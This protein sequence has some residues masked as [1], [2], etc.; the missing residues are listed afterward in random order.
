MTSPGRHF[1]GQLRAGGQELDNPWAE[2]VFAQI[3]DEVVLSVNQ[4]EVARLPTP[5]ITRTEQ[6]DVVLIEGADQAL[7]FR[8][9]DPTAFAEAVLPPL[10]TAELIAAASETPEDATLI[11]EPI[12]E[13]LDEAPIDAEPV[14]EVAA[15]WWRSWLVIIG[16]LLLLLILFLAFC[17][18][19]PETGISTTTTLAPGVTSS[20]PGTTT[21]TTLPATT[22]VPA[23]TT[24]TAVT[25]TT[26]PATTTSTA[27]A[28]T[29]SVP[30][31]V[32]AFGPGTQIVGEDVEPGIYE[33]GIVT[34]ILG[35]GW[36]RLS[37]LSGEAGDIIAGSPVENHGV[38]EIMA[39]DAA[40]DTDCEAW[41]PLTQVDPLMT[42]IPEGTWVLGTHIT[43]GTY[44][45]PG[46]NNCTWERLSG[47]SGEPEDVIA[48]EQP[49]GQAEVEIEPGDFA[50]DSVGCGDWAPS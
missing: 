39:T 38:A 6:S 2:A 8:P 3:G 5:V 1:E 24:S 49:T 50:F 41:Y 40:F 4:R 10:T 14:D 32:P 9:R 7:Y 15:P 19:D 44:Q 20:V 16:A 35:C 33:T 29:T 12:E 23:T 21:A 13:P 28:T 22:T 34:D 30:T 18:D 36:D 17:N 43:P 47:V 11:M 31:P 27:P 48:T 37:G 25:T 45:A 46:G 42:T 26:A